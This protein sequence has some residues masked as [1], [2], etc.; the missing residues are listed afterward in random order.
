MFVNLLCIIKYPEN[1]FVKLNVE[2][3]IE[4]NTVNITVVLE[5][6]LKKIILKNEFKKTNPNL[7]LCIILFSLEIIQH[8]FHYV[9]THSSSNIFLLH[10]SSNSR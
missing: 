8:A 10:F 4:C 2:G 5:L 9:H 7:L 6:N 1:A 3:H